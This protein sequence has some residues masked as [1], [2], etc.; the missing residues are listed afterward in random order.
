MLPIKLSDPLK[1]YSATTLRTG[2]RLVVSNAQPMKGSSKYT[3]ASSGGGKTLL[4]SF[5]DGERTQALTQLAGRYLAKGLDPDE[6]TQI[7]YDWNARQNPPL[8][9][10]KVRSTVAS[11]TKSD[12]RNHPERYEPHT[13][14]TPLFDITEADISAMLKTSP[15]AR[16]WLLQDMLPLGVVGMIVAPGGTGKSQLVLQLGVSIATG[17]P[18]CELWKVGEQGKALLLLAEDET[19]EVHRRLDR[20]VAELASANP[21][22]ASDLSQ[23]LLIKSMTARDNLMTRSQRNGDVATTDYVDRLL[24][25]VA[26]IP[27]LKL[28]VIDPASRFRGGNENSA[29]DVTRFV[30]QLERIRH[31]TGATIL[32]CHHANK[33]AMNEKSGTKGQ[34]ATRGSS[35]MTDGVRW[36]LNLAVPHKNALSGLDP[37]KR[38]LSAEGAKFNYGPPI[39]EEILVR[40]QGGYLTSVRASSATNTL[41]DRILQLIRD[42][43][44]AGRSHSAGGFEKQFGGEAGPLKAGKVKVRETIKRLIATGRLRKQKQQLVPFGNCPP[45]TE[46]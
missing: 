29:D 14:L 20:I 2:L 41:E 4:V 35:A 15:P 30:E 31:A 42:E 1:P 23:K 13:S 46:P 5:P 22:M 43:R 18:L 8:D 11:I 44:Q 32:L 27:D 40:K 45:S 12:A 3:A 33:A 9:S 38:Y 24:L 19:D 16:R 21:S 6:V 36:Q 7:A 39:E 17:V 10:E 28:I 34:A 37:T 25:T 26:G